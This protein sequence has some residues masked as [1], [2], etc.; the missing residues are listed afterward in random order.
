LRYNSGGDERLGKQLI[1]YL[2]E[3]TDINGFTEYGHNSK[4]Y[5]QSMDK[6][7]KEENEIYIQKYGET[8]PEGE[9]NVST[10]I[11]NETYFHD[12]EKVG[13]PFLLDNL[14][15]KFKGNVYVLIGGYTFSAASVLATT[16]YDNNLATFVGKPTGNKPSCQTGY[17][18]VKLPQTKELVHLS[19]MYMERPNKE[20]NDEIALFPHIEINPSFEK[21]YLSN[22]DESIDAILNMITI[23]EQN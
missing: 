16:M 4:F 21:S 1:W 15:S 17:S 23:S 8:L 18:S 19:I 14:I 7:Y 5:R 6:D 12:I 20:K 11:Y 10:D 9:Y 2:T 13:S 22:I 3:R